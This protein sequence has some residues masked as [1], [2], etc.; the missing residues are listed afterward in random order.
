MVHCVLGELTDSSSYGA[1]CVLGEL[2]DSS[3]YGASCVLGELTDM[4]LA[5]CAITG[6]NKQASLLYCIGVSSVTFPAANNNA[7]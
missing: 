1:L 6:S 7:I 4:Q 2:T 3:S 5:Y